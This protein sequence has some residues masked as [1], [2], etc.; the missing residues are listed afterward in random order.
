MV[1]KY[2]KLYDRYHDKV[3]HCILAHHGCRAWGSPVA[4]ST[5]E[6]WLVHLADAISARADDCDRVD[7]LKVD[8]EKKG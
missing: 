8:Q 3:L 6:A 7:M 4:P 1:C 2:P 5:R